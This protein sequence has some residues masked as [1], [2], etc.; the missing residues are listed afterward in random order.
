M[1]VRPGSGG[2]QQAVARVLDHDRAVRGQRRAS[3]APAGRCRAP[4]SCAGRCRRRTRRPRGRARRRRRAPAWPGPRARPRSRRR[5][6]ASP[7]PAP[8][9]TTRS[10][11][12]PGRD[13]AGG[14]QLGVDG[15]LA[16]VPGGDGGLLPG[17]VGGQAG[18]GHELRGEQAGQPFLAAAD[19]ELL[20]V[21]RHAPADREAELGER[22]VERG[23]VA[24]ALGVGQHPVAVEDEAPGARSSRRAGHPVTRPGPRCRSGACGRRPC[25]SPRPGPR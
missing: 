7:R 12:G 2:G 17:G 10:M 9:P 4:A 1:Q 16:P 19:A 11:P 20:L 13:R 8:R 15:G 21:L 5:P 6:A 18:G 14:D 25:P 22:L 23:Q 3:R 24:V